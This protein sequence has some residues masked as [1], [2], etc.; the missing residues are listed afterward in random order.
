MV[1]KTNVRV[2]D[3]TI[4]TETLKANLQQII[5]QELVIENYS[6][7]PDLQSSYLRRIESLD[8]AFLLI[9]KAIPKAANKEMPVIRDYLEWCKAEGVLPDNNVNVAQYEEKIGK[10]SQAV[11][12][13]LRW[14]EAKKLVPASSTIAYQDRNN[15]EILGY[16]EWCKKQVNDEIL[17]Y[18]EWC[19]KQV[20]MSPGKAIGGYQDILAKHTAHLVDAIIDYWFPVSL[21]EEIAAKSVF[22]KRS[23]SD[24]EK[25]IEAVELLNKAEQYVIMKEP[26]HSDVATLS[27]MGALGDEKFILQWEKQLPPCSAETLAELDIIKN[28]KIM[29]TPE[30]FRELPSYQQIYFQTST[31]DDA[32]EVKKNINALIEQLPQVTN[33]SPNDWE[34]ISLGNVRCLVEL[35]FTAE[36]QAFIKSISGESENIK[37]VIASIQKLSDE[38]PKELTNLQELRE[39]P[40]WFLRLSAHEQQL[41]KTCLIEQ[42]NVADVVSFLPSRLRTIPALANFAEHQLFILS[43]EGVLVKEFAK[44]LRLSNPSSRDAIGQPIQIGDLHTLRNIEMLLKYAGNRPLLLQTL[45]SP[46]RLYPFQDLIPDF[47]LDQQRRKIV[48]LLQKKGVPLYSTN[49]PLNVANKPYYTEADDI[50]CNALYSGITNYLTDAVKA[51][52]ELLGDSEGEQWGALISES[53]NF[54]RNNSKKNAYAKLIQLLDEMPSISFKNRSLSGCEMMIKEAF[55]DASFIE[56]SEHGFSEFTDEEK[57]A[58]FFAENYKELSQW[59]GWESVFAAHCYVKNNHPAPDE[60]VGLTTHFCDIAQINSDYGALLDSGM[61]TATVLDYNGRELWLSSLGNLQIILTGGVVSGACVSGKDRKAVELTHTDAILLY[62]EIYGKWPNIDDTGIDRENFVD[63]VSDL[64]I[65]RH[66]HQQAGKSATGADG[67]KHPHKYWPT[68]IAK[69]ILAKT[70]KLSLR[71]DDILATNNEVDRIGNKDNKE[72]KYTSPRH[73]VKN[74]FA[75]SVIAAKRFSSDERMRLL[76]VL[77]EVVEEK[78]FW[79]AQRLGLGNK[80]SAAISSFSSALSSSMSLLFQ[81]NSEKQGSSEKQSDSYTGPEGIVRIRDVL[82]P[83]SNF[84]EPLSIEKL[85]EVYYE[86]NQR[87]EENGSRTEATGFVYSCLREL[88]HHEKPNEIMDDIITKLDEFKREIY[89][90][91]SVCVA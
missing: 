26:E 56:G 34:E 91:N 4:I 55:E 79:A 31:G 27:T 64:Y 44:C 60:W 3:G 59:R 40:Y 80:V 28:S 45:I 89:P 6:Q 35:K 17:G 8:K 1:N 65:T 74:H 68:D 22:P 76:T 32:V 13:Y 7:S 83:V 5:Q 71:T 50:E 78:S 63:I 87:A 53:V 88:F 43:K 14:C 67:I 82:A 18:F 81:G 90:Q 41:L 24:L 25:V 15:D 10:D 16:F 47:R 9:M 52:T 38:L 23:F 72:C 61:G 49:H 21:K 57:L 48:A 37:A 62:R 29:V 11:I 39:L 84:S 73:W 86:L 2:K 42:E 69:A 46:I 70:N 33:F 77:K 12:D 30:W 19:K 66:H 36:Q 85:A 20:D 54:T 75:S 58:H 51:Q